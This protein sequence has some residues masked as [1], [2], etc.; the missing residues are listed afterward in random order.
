[1]LLSPAGLADL[2]NLVLEFTGRGGDGDDVADGCADER[3]ADGGLIGDLA[4]EAVGLGG[5]DDAVL[6]GLGLFH[7]LDYDGAA[8]VDAVGGDILLGNDFDVLQDL[9]EFFD[10][11]LDVALFVLG[12]IVLGVLGQVALFA[13]F[14]D[15]LR[16]FL[17]LDD[18]QLVQLVLVS[19]EAFVCQDIFLF[20]HNM[21]PAFPFSKRC[22][23]TCSI[24]FMGARR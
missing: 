9:L 6:L 13:R 15:L 11:G 20:F 4:H 18:L 21:I 8:D 24:F 17:A 12:C 2:Q 10:P 5:A 1:M 22:F 14:L 23:A 7:V 16:D 19:L 3:F